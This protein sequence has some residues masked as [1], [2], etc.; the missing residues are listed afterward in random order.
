MKSR[1]Y[2]DEKL[3]AAA[4]AHGFSQGY[5]MLYSPWTTIGAHSAIFLSLN[6][7]K[8]PV[9]AEM[10]VVSDERGNSYEVE[11]DTTQSPIT[12]QFLKLC[13]FIGV[14]PSRV[15]TGVAAPFRSE[16]WNTLSSTQRRAALSIGREF[17][18]EVLPNS[19]AR[20]IVTCSD[21]ASE[22]AVS[23]TG[24]R[25]DSVTPSGWGNITLSRYLAGGDRRIVKLPHLSQFKLFSRAEAEP[26]LKAIFEIGE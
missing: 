3:Q 18:S 13:D 1:E 15:L 11:R 9:A 10:C 6:P 7:G 17:W 5:K 26:F 23:I 8:P 12:A 2:W 14:K 19:P 20:L 21:E 16:R 22:L 4:K 25:L 24:A